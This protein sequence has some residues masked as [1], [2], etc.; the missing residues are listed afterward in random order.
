MTCLLIA[1]W[2]ESGNG[3]EISRLCI[4]SKVPL[5]IVECNCTKRSLGKFI[6]NSSSRVLMAPHRSVFTVSRLRERSLSHAFPIRRSLYSKVRS[7]LACESMVGDLFT[8][9]MLLYAGIKK[10]FTGR[11][12]WL[13]RHISTNV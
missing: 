3:L 4:E 5:R 9:P 6:F 11:V 12:R 2:Y 7:Q 10:N 8:I 1:G 13:G